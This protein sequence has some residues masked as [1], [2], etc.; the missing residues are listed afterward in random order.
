MTWCLVKKHMHKLSSLKALF[1]IVR[2]GASGGAPLLG[3]LE[4]MLG[5][6]L[7]AG[8]VSMGAPVPSNGNL[9]C[10]GGDF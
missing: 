4:D 9:V 8:I 10:L 1:N 2:E 7:D 6:S 5:K 3:T